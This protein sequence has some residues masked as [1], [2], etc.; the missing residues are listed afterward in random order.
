M[1]MATEQDEKWI[2]A[3]KP[4]WG[5]GIVPFWKLADGGI[6]AAK[7]IDHLMRAKDAKKIGPKGEYLEWPKP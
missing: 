3:L 1:T 7:T 6:D 5:G 2:D 4:Y